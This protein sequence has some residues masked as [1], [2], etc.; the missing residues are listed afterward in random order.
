MLIP[1]VNRSNK[2]VQ[3]VME[4]RML[5]SSVD[6]TIKQY[7]LLHRVSEQERAQHELAMITNRDKGSLTRL[8]QSLERK[9]FVTRRVCATDSRM[10]LVKITRKGRSALKKGSDIVKQ[11][12][13]DITQDLSKT[14]T[15]SMLK[16]C[17]KM[18][19]RASELFEKGQQK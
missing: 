18:N 10:N 8:I 12:F 13:K 15:E 19:T 17:A 1:V 9:D 7:I 6:L 5:C 3:L 2:M 14:E 16:C 4:Q 11:A